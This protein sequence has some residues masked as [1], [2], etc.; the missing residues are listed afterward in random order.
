MVKDIS[1]IFG[2]AEGALAVPDIDTYQGIM[3]TL[4][5]LE[6]LYGLTITKLDDQVCLKMDV[7]HDNYSRVLA[8]DL[9]SWYGVKE[10]VTSGSM[11]VSDYDEWRYT[12]PECKAEEQRISREE[13]ASIPSKEGAY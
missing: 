5:V 12:Y 3:H 9:R 11:L 4:F 7:N 8:E 1:R 6:D 10:K 2:V 13:I